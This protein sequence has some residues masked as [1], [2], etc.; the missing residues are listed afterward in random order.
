MRVRLLVDI[1]WPE[2]RIMEL[3]ALAGEQAGITL[4]LP[5]AD[6]HMAGRIMG[7]QPVEGFT[8]PGSATRVPPTKG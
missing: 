2:D 7:A 6:T 8:N 1:E 4:Y 3:G 5:T